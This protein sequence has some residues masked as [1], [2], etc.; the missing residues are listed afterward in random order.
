[1]NQK[2]NS[3]AQKAAGEIL[4][5]I[6]VEKEFRPG[7]KL[8]NEIELAARLGVSRATL[9]EGIRLL[10]S[11]NVLEVRRG[12]GTFVAQRGS[13]E[14]PLDRR[15]LLR[16][17]VDLRSVYELRLMVEPQ[18][19]Y[20]A[21]R[22]GT[23]SEIGRIL[24]YGEREEREIAAG[25]DRTESERAFH[26]SI[27]LAAHNEFVQRLLPVIYEAIDSGVRLSESYAGVVEDTRAD[28]HM[29]MEALRARDALA[30]R[31]AM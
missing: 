11:R 13:H 28:H 14:R 30:A 9:R 23:E 8:P 5:L 29:L 27:A 2:D 12:L 20:Y 3:L 22:R 25:E 17:P 1:M 6:T 15:E 21:A 10:T 18:T 26:K 31:A 19:A 16:T 7:D 24:F 4:S